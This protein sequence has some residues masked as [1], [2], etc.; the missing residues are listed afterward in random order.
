MSRQIRLAGIIGVAVA[1][2]LGSNALAQSFKQENPIPSKPSQAIG[3]IERSFVTLKTPER[4]MLFPQIK[5]RL[6]DTPAFLRDSGAAFNFR[7]YYRDNLTNASPGGSGWSEAWTMGGSVSVETGRL[8]NLISGGM[9]IY[10]SL[11]LYAPLDHD[12]T[13]L[14]RPGQQSY[15]VV[16]QLYGKVHL[17]EQNEIVAGRYLYD[18][19]FIGPQD[20]RMTPKTF[21]GYTL[22]GSY[23]ERD[24]SAPYFQ[25]GAG[26]IAAMKERNSTEFISMSRSAGANQDYGVGVAG[27]LMRWGPV[28]VG[29]IEYYNQDT[30]NIFY[31]EGRVGHDFGDASVELQSQFAAQ[32]SVGLNLL[33][34][35]TYWATNQFGTQLQVGYSTG[36]LTAAYSVVNPGFNM[37][38]PWSANPFY[39]DALIRSFNLAGENTVMFGASYV[40]TPIGLPGVAA[41]V[42]YFHGWGGAPAAGGPLIQDEWNFNLEWR[43]NW[44]PLQ[45]LWLRASYGQAWTQQAGVTTVVDEVRLIL[46]YGLKFY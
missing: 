27:G 23:G 3:A 29:A 14:L 42:F 9:V 37:Q 43:P 46:N 39:T 38:T 8:W 16:G 34:S 32:N 31:A 44:K 12:G 11:P 33:N 15:G 5:E 17:D 28:H 13:G 40:M 2:A 7:S 1:G 45:G 18:T 6:H 41:S 22:M 20:N 21:Y 25:Y 26:Y 30:I 24:S 19:P 4:L 35:G 36:I 10:T